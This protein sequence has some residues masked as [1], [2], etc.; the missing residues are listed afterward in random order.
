MRLSDLLHCRVTSTAGRQLGRVVDVRLVQDG[1][2]VDGFGSALRV[3]GL[4]V[5]RSAL[6]SR[7][8]YHRGGLK[9]PWL[10]RVL[11]RALE[12]RALQISWA[13]VASWDPEERVLCATVE[14]A[15][16]DRYKPRP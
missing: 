12:R 6:G 13:D 1:P 9:G 8:G 4:L 11:F 2:M 14:M 5:G 10:L 7:L 15:S 3:E 16:D